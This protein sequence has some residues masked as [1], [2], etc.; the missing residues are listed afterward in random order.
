MRVLELKSGDL[1]FKTEQ[2]VD[3]LL[4]GKFSCFNSPLTLHHSFF[5]NYN[6]SLKTAEAARMSNN[7]IAVFT[8]GFLLI[9]FWFGYHANQIVVYKSCYTTEEYGVARKTFLSEGDLL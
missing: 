9:I 1:G 4:A 2:Q 7:N 3:F 6:S 8:L 5:K